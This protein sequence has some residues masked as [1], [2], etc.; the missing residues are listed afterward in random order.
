MNTKKHR[1]ARAVYAIMLMMLAA[2]SLSSCS[3][4]PEWADPEAHEKTEKLREQYMPIIVGKWHIESVK[5]NVRF[6]ECLT[7]CEDGSLKGMRRWQSRK[8]VTI[9]GKEQYTD[10]QD[11]EDENGTF[12]GTWKLSW[13]RDSEDAFSGNRLMLSASFDEE[14]DWPSPYAYG[15]NALF[16]NADETT[17]SIGG[18]IIHNGDDGSMVFTRGSAEPSF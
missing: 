9:G 8:L 14:R 2:F 1:N 16:I 3:S 7:F 13:M 17:L 12:T 5:D 15:L 4:D 6:F 11:V 10:W 18:G